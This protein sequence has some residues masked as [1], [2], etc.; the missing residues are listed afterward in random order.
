MELR[1]RG[2]AV[3][4]DVTGVVAVTVV[5]GTR[6]GSLW[7][8]GGGDGVRSRS[9]VPGFWATGS[10]SE[11]VLFGL[12]TE[13]VSTVFSGDTC[14][15]ANVGCFGDVSSG[16]LLSLPCS[17]GVNGLS[18]LEHGDGPTEGREEGGSTRSTP[19]C[20]VGSGSEDIGGTEGGIGT[21][22]A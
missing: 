10:I 2:V 12:E 4:V 20:L 1:H 6:T 5:G 11:A 3:L 15:G 8:S 19:T 7:S 18:I 21:S 17:E 16:S 9:V 14:I 22:N 13:F